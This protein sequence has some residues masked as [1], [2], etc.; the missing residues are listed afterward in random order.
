MKA[1]K[2]FDTHVT[3]KAGSAM[4]VTFRSGK[5]YALNSSE[6]KRMIDKN[7]DGNNIYNQ[8]IER[9]CSLYG[10]EISESSAFYTH[11]QGWNIPRSTVKP[12]LVTLKGIVPTQTLWETLI[13][14]DIC[15]D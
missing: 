5:S 10:N 3:F 12:K 13:F 4:I 14:N 11:T 7:V 9:L 15:G 1:Y 8:M 2:I 6:I